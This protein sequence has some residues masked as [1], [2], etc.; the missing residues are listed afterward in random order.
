MTQGDLNGNLNKPSLQGQNFIVL[1]LSSKVEYAVLALLELASQPPPATPL[2][3]GEIA[4]KQPI[5]ERYLEQ[6]LT[7]LR[8]GGMIHSQRGA[9]GGFVLVRKPWQITMLEIVCLVESDRK[10]REL[11]ESSTLER[12]VVREM[13]QQTNLAAQ[14]ILSSITLQDLCHKCDTHRRIQPMYYI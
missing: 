9:K 7:H 8:R 4:A 1:E 12:G 10:E 13:W 3:I 6:I 2:T 5:P 11:G 14:K